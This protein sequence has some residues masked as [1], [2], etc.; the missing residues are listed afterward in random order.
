MC[1][2]K[3]IGIG[4]QHLYRSP[5]PVTNTQQ[6]R[7]ISKF[8]I[9]RLLKDNNVCLHSPQPPPYYCI[10]I[11]GPS[12][13][14]RQ[15][16]ADV[17]FDSKITQSILQHTLLTTFA[18]AVMCFTIVRLLPCCILLFIKTPKEHTLFKLL[19]RLEDGVQQIKI[20]M[21]QGDLTVK[22]QH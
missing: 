20:K 16:Y 3:S 12:A 19:F 8:R 10:V 2:I 22:V 7:T 15:E 18:G 5:F 1:F 21:N 9:F 4:A 11:Q 17:S 6:R 14:V 13:S